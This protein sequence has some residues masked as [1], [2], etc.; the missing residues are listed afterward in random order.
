MRD[1][2]ETRALNESSALLQSQKLESGLTPTMSLNNCMTSR[3]NENFQVIRWFTNLM[4][5]Q[6]VSGIHILVGSKDMM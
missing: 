3:H 2:Q 6:L 1:K 4:G 5:Q